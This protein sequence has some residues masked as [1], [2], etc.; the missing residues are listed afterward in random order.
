[1]LLIAAKGKCE[2]MK[3]SATAPQ[4]VSRSADVGGC[5]A[6]VSV[7]AAARRDHR[8]DTKFTIRNRGERPVVFQEFSGLPPCIAALTNVSTRRPVPF[9]AL[10]H[11]VL[12]GEYFG[13]GSGVRVRLP[14][15]ESFTLA[16]DLNEYYSLAPGEYEMTVRIRVR[17]E[18]AERSVELAVDKLN[19]KITE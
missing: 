8:V 2:D 14:A 10:G 4:M 12:S 11:K 9:T 5:A 15:G 18:G 16:V 13:G 19:F 3:P 1:M 6:E 7:S 17:P